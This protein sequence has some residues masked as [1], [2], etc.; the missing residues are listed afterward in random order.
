MRERERE[1]RGG[2]MA[3]FI[4]QTAAVLS[5]ETKATIPPFIV[6][7]SQIQSSKKKQ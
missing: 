2:I 6:N 3:Q 4:C 5:N 7:L 1:E